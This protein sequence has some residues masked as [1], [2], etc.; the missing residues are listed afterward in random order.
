MIPE[1]TAEERRRRR[2][3]EAL[4]PTAGDPGTST[5]PMTLDERQR[6][7]EALKLLAPA[8][9][10]KRTPGAEARPDPVMQT[11]Q[12]LAEIAP[13]TGELISANDFNEARK[14]GDKLGM[15]LA[16]VGMLPVVGA[17]GRAGKKG[18]AKL[19]EE[20]LE[21]LAKK[22]GK[23][24]AANLTDESVAKVFE[25]LTPEE[26]LK[27]A[28]QGRH[29]KQNAN[30]AQYIGAPRGLDSPGKLGANRVRVDSKVEAGLFNAPWYDRARD[31]ISRVSGFDPATMA[32]DS[33]EGLRA[34]LLSRGGAAYSPQASPKKETNDFLK[35]YIAKTI[36]GTDVKP[37]MQAQA[38]NVARGMDIDPFTGRTKLTPDEIKLG[39]K[40]GPYGDAKDPTIPDEDLYDTANDLW[41][42]RVMGYVGNK[43]D[44]EGLF[45]RGFT[46]AE[47]GWMTGENLL[48]A[49]RAQDRGLIP[50]GMESFNWTPR[51]VQAATWGAERKAQALVEEGEREA[52]YLKELAKFE[53]AK[54][55]GK[56]GLTKPTAPKRMTEKELMDYSKYGID[57]ALGEQVAAI[58]PEF[59]PGGGTGLLTG[60]DKLPESLRN[61]FSRQSLEAS[62]KYNPVLR[63]LEQYQEPVQM[64][65][66]EWVDDLTGA[67]ESNLSDV[68]RPLIGTDANILK[69]ATE[70]KEAVKGGQMLSPASKAMMEF[71]AGVEGVTRGQQG[72][73]MRNFI[74]ANSSFSAS[75]KT[76][77]RIAGSA[78]ELAKAKQAL[79]GAG[80][81]VLDDGDGLLVGR[82]ASDGQT[83][84]TG[85]DGKEIQ[86]KI[87]DA[88]V[89]APISVSIEPG[90]L[91]MGLERMPWGAEGSGQVAQYLDRQLSR[92]DVI[93]GAQRLDEGGLPSVLDQRY[94]VAETFGREQGLP[95]RGDMQKLMDLLRQPNGFQKFQEYVKKNG[96]EGLPAI[97]MMLGGAGLASQSLPARRDE[98]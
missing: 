92:P 53:R 22:S 31:A 26:A 49:K 71:T 11:L 56:K 12:F 70:T 55:A 64:V 19:A 39:E 21:A 65:R 9:A 5:S 86:K 72:V 91:E 8:D 4:M 29:L 87:K 2:L 30:T 95:I 97:A 69:A 20:G 74:P 90:R 77:A 63:A 28:M 54:A 1:L 79:Q 58:T 75:E 33:P 80:L 82:F 42:G 7:M 25:N 88:I 67:L 37:A 14:G 48:M 60:F 73:G 66:G 57:D 89:N 93:A 47:H 6:Q 61:Q 52:K 85:L 94:K 84:N 62:G 76:G 3:Y 98:Y 81:D 17:V 34:K 13:G 83:W 43:T 51:R 32:A 27:A 44:P 18:A 23:V 24:A 35:Q 41:H 96:Y 15:A 10:T 78:E 16:A 46:A 38:D 59:A 36:S 45:D 50:E 40:T 68:A